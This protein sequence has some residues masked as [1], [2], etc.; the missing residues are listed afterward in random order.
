M[1]AQSTLSPGLRR[2]MA[3]RTMRLAV[4]S[5]L[6]LV[7]SLQSHP[8]LP[9][10]KTGETWRNHV[11]HRVPMDKYLDVRLAPWAWN[12]D[13]ALQM[14]HSNSGGPPVTT[15]SPRTIRSSSAVS[16]LQRKIGRGV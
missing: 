2:P 8:Q 5:I 13:Q 14:H 7:V 10:A 15:L 6:I 3:L 12:A 9:K 4:A 1:P 11:S 16:T